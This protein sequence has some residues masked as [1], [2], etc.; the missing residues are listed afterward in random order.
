[1]TTPIDYRA[2]LQALYD[3]VTAEKWDAMAHR[4][5]IERAQ[6][7]LAAPEAVGVADEVK[8]AIDEFRY[9][10][11]KYCVDS[12]AGTRY[13][14]EMAAEECRLLGINPSEITPTGFAHPAPIPVGE[15]LP[16]AGVK[17]LAHYMNSHGKSRSVC[18]RWIPAKFNS[19]E[20]DNYDGDFLEY[21][22]DSDTYYW[23]E[24]WYEVI[25]NCDDYGSVTIHEGEVTHWRPLPHWS[26]PLPGAQP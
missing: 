11:G 24:G 6:A 23:P 19:D 8:A 3:D 18:A 20:S 2:E 14:L 21:D 9:Q 22:E 4:A 25:E 13:A 12:S 15:R 1:M 17:V 26:L 5:A 7:A 10:A 16:E